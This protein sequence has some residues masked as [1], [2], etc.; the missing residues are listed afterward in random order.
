MMSYLFKNYNG[1]KVAWLPELDGG[2]SETYKEFLV[3]IKKTV[4]KVDRICEFCAGP[5]FIG[6]SLLAEG[7]CNSLCLIDINPEA[8]KAMQETIKLNNL[9]DKVTVY[10]S[11]GLNNVPESE[12]WDLVVS[13]PP[14]FKAQTQ[15][16][17][18]KNIILK[19]PNWSIHKNFFR[20]V[21]KFMKPHSTIIMQECYMGVEE[22]DFLPFLK[23]GN[24][25]LID[26]FM[27]KKPDNQ[28]RDVYFYLLIKQ[29]HNELIMGDKP[30]DII[31]I[32]LSNLNNK[33]ELKSWNKYRFEII[34]DS[35]E[36]KNITLLNGID[37]TGKDIKVFSLEI[38]PDNKEQSNIFYLTPGSYDL[39]DYDSKECL[40]KIEV[41]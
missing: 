41:K 32:K 12:K 36:N 31:N 4:G 38:L 22:K 39:I 24:L 7:L 23:D 25:H 18:E 33:T 13:N 5:S 1:L 2:G 19:D 15:E 20:D 17:Y 40:S 10:L 30:I 37:K 8:V 29:E 21:N 34:N 16:E 27:F 26:T 28:W 14:H 3:I 6:F 35:K 11:D 9:Q